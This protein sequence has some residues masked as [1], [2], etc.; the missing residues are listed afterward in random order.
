[1]K[2]VAEI[3]IL[4]VCVMEWNCEG[5]DF[6]LSIKSIE[7]FTR[8]RN[9]LLVWNTGEK[10]SRNK[11]LS[12]YRTLSPSNQ[13]KF[14]IKY[15]MKSIL[16]FPYYRQQS[17]KYTYSS[18]LISAALFPIHFSSIY[19]RKSESPNVIFLYQCVL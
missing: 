7:S 10:N 14:L 1:M 15:C 2:Q 3:H 9:S 11:I 8:T 6:S 12:L 13:P 5:V 17:S 16:I 18:G 19:V 4:N